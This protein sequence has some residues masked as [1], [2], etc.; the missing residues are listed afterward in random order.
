[1][2]PYIYLEHTADAC[3][4]A[5]GKT[6]EEAFSN[7]AIATFNIIVNTKKVKSKQKIEIK[8]K[9]KRLISLLYD[10]LDELLFRMDKDRFVLSK[11]ENIKIKE[12]KTGFEL[13]SV[14]SGDNA[15]NYDVTAEIK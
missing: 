3:F 8:V 15:K 4:K 12:T 5:Y 13:T 11:I 9:S 2:K 10:F 14:L 7:S 6:L 1:M